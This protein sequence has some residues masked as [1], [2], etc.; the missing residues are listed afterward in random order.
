MTNG[1]PSITIAALVAISGCDLKYEPD[2]GP[3]HAVVVDAPSPTD[4]PS[5]TT[6]A[7]AGPCADSDP[8][9]AVT[10]SGHIRPILGKSPGG[11]TGCHGT[12]ATS[13]FTVGSY[14]AILRG[15][16]VSGSDIV[17]PGE[18]CESVL[19]QKLSATPPFGSRMPYNGPPFFTASELAMFR[20]WIAEGALD[21]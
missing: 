12:S 6:L 7:A 11:C 2:V 21:N 19:Y 5:D 20:D 14:D 3:L 15:G 4:A 16:T 1:P 13:G 9:V 18:P 17:I 8:L 10:F